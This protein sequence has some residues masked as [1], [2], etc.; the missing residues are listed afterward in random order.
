MDVWRRGSKQWLT[1][2]D[3][4]EGNQSCLRLQ[5][6]S[7]ETNLIMGLLMARLGGVGGSFLR[8]LNSFFTFKVCFSG[9]GHVVNEAETTPPPRRANFITVGDDI[10]PKQLALSSDL[11]SVSTGFGAF[12]DN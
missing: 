6:W 4:Y 3:G 11:G 12:K 8:K 9:R 7:R 1:L 10:M 2:P 5:R